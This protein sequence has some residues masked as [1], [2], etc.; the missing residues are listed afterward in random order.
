LAPEDTPRRLKRRLA[1]LAAFPERLHLVTNWPRGAE[2]CAALKAWLTDHPGARLVIID[3]LARIRAEQTREQNA[4]S[5]DYE[6]VGALKAV[7]DAHGVALLLLH[8]LRKMGAADPFDTVSGTLGLSGAA[9]SVLILA[10][11]HGHPEEPIL[12]A[13]AFI[14]QDVARGRVAPEP[15]LL[16]ERRAHPS[17]LAQQVDEVHTTR[18]PNCSRA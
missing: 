2:A 1:T 10:K 7:A 18:M 13:A 16:S 9:D 8:H 11:E 5:A 14:G 12:S 3:T 15:P 17:S 6:A 4:Y